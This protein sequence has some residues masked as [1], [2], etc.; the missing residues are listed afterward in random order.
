[1]RTLH[2]EVDDTFIPEEL[3]DRDKWIDALLGKGEKKYDQGSDVLRRM[4]KYCCLGVRSDLQG[5]LQR[6]GD[7][8][9]DGGDGDYS[10]LS[11]DCT[12]NKPLSKSGYIPY[13]VFIY[14]IGEPDEDG[15]PT[16]RTYVNLAEINDD[17]WK[18]DVIAQII[19]ICWREPR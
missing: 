11:S 17:G 13:G 14:Y 16:R 4:D 7:R 15:E 6:S 8:W 19:S 2:I 9:R 10:F 3:V 12:D 1:M 18:F 5:R